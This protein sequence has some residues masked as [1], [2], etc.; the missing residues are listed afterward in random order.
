MDRFG[1]REDHV[2]AAL[3]WVAERASQLKFRGEL[4]GYTPLSLLEEVET[5]SLGV[6]GKL[7]RWS[8]SPHPRRGPAAGA[9]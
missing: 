6:E 8:H 3:G 2:K 1:A 4:R 5:L 7:A 9:D